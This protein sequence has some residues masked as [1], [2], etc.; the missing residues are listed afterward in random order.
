MMFLILQT[1]IGHN[2]WNVGFVS[3]PH[4]LHITKKCL[5]SLVPRC[6]GNMLVTKYPPPIL[7]VISQ[8]MK[9]VVVKRNAVINFLI[10]SVLDLVAAFQFHG[11][12]MV[13]L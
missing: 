9:H 11:S 12:Y 2:G 3:K 1:D 8:P 4:P 5:V 13:P 10:S 6:S 7:G